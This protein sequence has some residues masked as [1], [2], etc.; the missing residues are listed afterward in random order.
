MRSVLVASGALMLSHTAFAGLPTT[1]TE[2]FALRTECGKLGKALLEEIVKNRE[3]LKEKD[4]TVGEVSSF[5]STNYNQTTNHC[6][7]KVTHTLPKEKT[8]YS[9]LYDGQ[10]GGMIAIW[11]SRFAQIKGESV[12][13]SAAYDYIEKMMKDDFGEDKK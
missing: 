10:G 9:V 2:I 1:A 7:V 6:Y 12:P 3:L 5:V 4:N 11:M 8:S 13:A